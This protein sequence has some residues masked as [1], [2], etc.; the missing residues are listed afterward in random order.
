MESN[1]QHTDY[2]QD[3]MDTSNDKPSSAM[4]LLSRRL[5][6]RKL[7]A[8]FGALAGGALLAACGGQPSAPAS[9]AAPTKAA[10]GAA[11]APTAAAAAQ[12]TAAAAPAVVKKGGTI[13]WLGH[14]V[15]DALTKDLRAQYQQM[16]GTEVKFEGIPYPGLRD[17]I[18]LELAS[19]SASYDLVTMGSQWWTFDVNSK[20]ESLDNLIKADQPEKPADLNSGLTD[21]FKVQGQQI[22]WPLRSGVFILHYRKD[23]Y[24]AAGLQPPKTF[25]D[26]RANAQKLNKPPDQFGAY[27]MGTADGFASDDFINY[28][29]SFGGKILTDDFKSCV[30][31]SEAGYAAAEYWASLIKGGL[32]PPGTASHNY[33]DLIAALQQGLAAQAIAFSPYAVDINDPKKSKFSGKFDWALVPVDKKSGLDHSSTFL[34]CW[35]VFIPK[36]SARKDTTWNFVSWLTNGKNDIAMAMS[37]NGPVR[38]PTFDDAA[39]K[40]INPSGAVTVKAMTYGNLG[41]PA[42]P[43][44]PQIQNVLTTQFNAVAAG[45]KSPKEAIDESTKQIQALL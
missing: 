4:P 34:Q 7:L 35:G 18:Y 37:G 31:N 17:K 45:T 19:N 24:D 26:Y 38:N 11:P 9:T 21:L 42:A 15:F 43:K 41:I 1:G 2:R 8:G 28:L 32:V 6:R 12:P 40:E 20:I 33:S 22:G 39:Y 3:P 14:P 16:T 30:L 36:A 10:S 23:L 27:V 44:R 29:Y 13:N 25:D 5:S